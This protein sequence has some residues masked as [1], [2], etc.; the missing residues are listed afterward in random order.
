LDMVYRSRY[1]ML[2]V[3]CVVIMMFVGVDIDVH[4]KC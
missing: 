1:S 2:C 3:V 4:N